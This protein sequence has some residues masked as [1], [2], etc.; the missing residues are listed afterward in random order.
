[1]PAFTKNQANRCRLELRCGKTTNGTPLTA[2]GRRV[3]I[4]KLRRR[5]PLILERY[6]AAELARIQALEDMGDAPESTV[7]DPVAP[8]S[9]TEPESRGPDDLY[10]MRYVGIL[11]DVL[12]IGRSNNV[13]TRRR[14]L[15][16]CQNFHV[17]VLATFPGK[18]H[19]ESEVHKRLAERRSARGPGREWFRIDLQGALEAVAKASFEHERLHPEMPM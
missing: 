2:E 14:A 18:G 15:E 1:M 4:A 3:R 16:S 11:Q 19:L 7:E 10:I 9:E 6:R 17:E 12:K 8:P 13:E 5:V